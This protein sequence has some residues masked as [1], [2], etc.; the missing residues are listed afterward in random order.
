MQLQLQKIQSDWPR[1]ND[2]QN[3]TLEKAQLGPDLAVCLVSIFRWT[4]TSYTLISLVQSHKLHVA[5]MTSAKDAGKGKMVYHVYMACYNFN[6]VI[7]I[8]Q[9][10]L[11]LRKKKK[12]FICFNRESK[13]DQQIQSS[14]C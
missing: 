4:E 7:L 2:V 13:L 1:N 5:Y 6:L 8:D 10:T 9:S 12:K 11:K 14:M 3:K